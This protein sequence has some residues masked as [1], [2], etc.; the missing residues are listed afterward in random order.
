MIP[1][2]VALATMTLKGLLGLE[3]VRERATRQLIKECWGAD[4]TKH[5][6]FEQICIPL[7]TIL[8]IGEEGCKQES[9]TSKH[10]DTQKTVSFL[11]SMI[12]DL[13]AAEDCFFC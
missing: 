3:R 9:L 8:M 4:S 13:E 5:P 1:P 6:N 10:C 2:R 11:S 12:T 7:R